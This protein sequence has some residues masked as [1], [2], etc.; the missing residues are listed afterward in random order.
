MRWSKAVLLLSIAAAAATTIITSAAATATIANNDDTKNTNRVKVPLHRRLVDAL[1]ETAASG[2]SSLNTNLR[3]FEIEAELHDAANNG[4]KKA[5]TLLKVDEKEPAITSRT[6]FRFP[7]HRFFDLNHIQ[8]V[9]ILASRGNHGE[10]FNNDSS[11]NYGGLTILSVNKATGDVRGIQHGGGRDSGTKRIS[12]DSSSDNKLKLETIAS[13]NDDGRGLREKATNWTCGA[14]H[15][16]N[17]HDEQ[18]EEDRHYHRHH[19]HSRSLQHNHHH[20]Q[21]HSQNIIYEYANTR[22][23]NSPTTTTWI[24]PKKYK[25]HIPLY[26]EIDSTFVNRQGGLNEAIEYVTFL[27]TAVN[28]ILEQEIDTH[29][30]VVH[31][32]ETH[33]YDNI[34]ST[35]AA[36]R[37]Q[38]LRPRDNLAGSN[39]Y[40]VDGDDKIILVHALLGRHVGGGI[41]YIDTICDRKWSFGITSDIHGSFTNLGKE[42]LLDMFMYAHELGHSLGS[43]HTYDDYEP[44]VDTCGALCTLSD[45]LKSDPVGLPLDHSATIMSY[46]NFCTGGVDNIALTYG[47]LWDGNTPQSDIGHWMNHPD[48]AGIGTVSVEPKRVSHTIWNALSDKAQECVEPPF[49]S[50]MLQGCNDSSDCNDNNICT[51]DMCSPDGVCVVSETLGNCCG[52]GV[53][54][55]GEISADCSDCGPYTIKPSMPC[56]ECHALDGFILDVGVSEN[57]NQAITLTS[58]ALRHKEPTQF[59]SN[60]EVFVARSLKSGQATKLTASL[61]Q[62]VTTAT[63]P[64]SNG[65]MEIK[66]PSP[67]TIDVA[68]KVELY[69]AASE[70]LIQF[71]VGAYSIENDHGVQLHSNRAVSGRFGTAV[72]SFSLNCEVKY[73]VEKVSSFLPLYIDEFRNERLSALPGDTSAVEPTVTIPDSSVSEAQAKSPPANTMSEL[74]APDRNDEVSAATMYMSIASSSAT[75]VVLLALL[76][77]MM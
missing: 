72:E 1:S 42:A 27:T 16:H 3:Q 28:I 15:V 23:L 60:V 52:N 8:N 38:R 26:I 30:E 4:G 35:Q 63:V 47:G 10:E 73:L 66:F 31:V 61:W 55:Q 75:T 76:R 37:A 2:T 68:G 71:G 49:Q 20:H 45:E 56:E 69:I 17:R 12:F 44:A 36:L 9:A 13:S 50:E 43:G 24:P 41:A 25:F 34:T 22:S 14:E 57:A 18:D 11:S 39:Y 58:I 7:K 32:E 62:G 51:I 29:L 70:E 65:M 21:Q 64:D 74:T 54:E 59:R 53:C 19:H 67:I 77:A 48:I 5:T 6:T 33:I 46:C 40:G